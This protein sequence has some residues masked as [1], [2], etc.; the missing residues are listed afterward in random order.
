MGLTNGVLDVAINV[1][2][3]A[4]ERRRG[5]RMLASMHAAF[6]FGAMTGAGGGAIAAAAGLEPALH[7]ALVTAT[8]SA[9]AA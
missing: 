6:S 1:E 7:L 3:A 5:R 9:V 4:L 2:G 8:V